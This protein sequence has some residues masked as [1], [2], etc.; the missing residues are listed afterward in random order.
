M[1]KLEGIVKEIVDE[2][3]YLKAREERFQ[4]TNSTFLPLSL[5]PPPRSSLTSMGSVDTGSREELRM[6]HVR[7]PRWLGRVADLPPSRVLQAQI[8]H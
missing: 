1:R 8:S 2:M 7:V 3:D 6:V 5:S 4:K